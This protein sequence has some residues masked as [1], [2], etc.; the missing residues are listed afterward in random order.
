MYS[1]SLT[2][3]CKMI[4]YKKASIVATAQQS[5]K[6]NN[7]ALSNCEHTKIEKFLKIFNFRIVAMTN[8]SVAVTISV[9]EEL[10]FTN[11]FRIICPVSFPVYCGCRNAVCSWQ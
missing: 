2:L 9:Y 10:A 3:H 6:K 5:L 4:L 11:N 1:L 7:L 8:D